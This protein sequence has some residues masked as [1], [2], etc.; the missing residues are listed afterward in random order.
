MALRTDV[1]VPDCGAGAGALPLPVAAVQAVFRAVGMT[2]TT[3]PVQT[4]CDV[5]ADQ[6][7]PVAWPAITAEEDRRHWSSYVTPR[8]LPR[9][10][11]NRPRAEQLALFD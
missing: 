5:T 8:R 11:T 2:W 1:P 3:G 9:L 7:E 4:L 6:D 10:T